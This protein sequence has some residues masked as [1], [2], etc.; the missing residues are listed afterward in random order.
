MNT[1]IISQ[2]GQSAGISF[3]VPINA[4]V[5]IVKPLIEHGRVIRADLGVTRVFATSKG[6]LV[7]S[8]AE[9]GPADRAGIEPIKTQIVQ[10]GGM[11]F[12]RLDPETADVIVAIDGKQVNNVDELLTQV[13]VAHPRRGC[14]RHGGPRRPAG[15]R[16]GHA[17][18]V[19]SGGRRREAGW[20]PA[21]GSP[22]P[23]DAGAVTWWTE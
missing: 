23:P 7:L 9:G 13:E 6:L 20:A 1:A 14:P 5:R 11:R 4:I 15:R 21:P 16:T 19:V 17:R 8:V 12:R 2:V 10:Y 3:A 22:S 18:A